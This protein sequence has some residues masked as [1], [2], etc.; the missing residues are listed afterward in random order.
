MTV[1]KLQLP[2]TGFTDGLNT[3]ASALNV[4]PSELMDGSVN[5]ELLRNGEIRRRR[6]VDFIGS[7]TGG[8]YLQ[9]IRTYSL[10]AEP[11]MESPSGVYVRL[12]A[13]NGSIVERIVIDVDNEFRIYDS[14]NSA[15]RNFDSPLQTIDRTTHSSTNQKFYPMAFA[16]SGNKLFFAGRHTVPGFMK[17]DDDNST[18]VV[19]YNDVLIRDPDATAKNTRRQRNSKWYECIEAHT[20]SAANRPGDGTGDWERYWVQLEGIIASGTTAWASGQAYTSTFI[21]LYDKNVTATNDETYPTTVEV[22]SG[23]LILS[24]DPKNSNDI[25][26][27]RVIRSDRDVEKFYQFADPFDANDPDLV[28]DDGFVLSLQGSGAVRQLLS[29]NAA[30]YVGTTTGVNQ[31]EG[32]SADFVA[33]DFSNF[34]VLND[35]I[36]NS[37]QMVRIDK[38]FMVF[39]QNGIWVSAI[40]RDFGIS[41]DGSTVFKSVSD[42]RVTS[43][44]SNIPEKSK[45]SAMAVY[46]NSKKKV[47]YFFNNVVTDFDRAY[48]AFDNPGYFTHTLVIDATSSDSSLGNI[49]DREKKIYR[50]TLGSIVLYEFADNGSDGSPYISYPFTSIGVPTANDPV[51]VGGDQVV[52]NGEDVVT[53]GQEQSGDVVLFITMG[54][55]TTEGT[56]TVQG[57]FG[58]L[59]GTAVRDWDQDAANAMS[60]TTRLVTGVSTLGNVEADKA[61]MYLFLVFKKVESDVLDDNGFDITPGGCFL[62]TA[63]SFST[64]AA[65][66]KYSAQRQVYVPDRFGYAYASGNYDGFNHSWYRHRVRGRG[67]VLSLVF[68]NDGDKDFH[69]V[70]WTYKFHAK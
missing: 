46:S 37:S 60:Y 44:Y 40:E 33:T 27:S 65:S 17:V 32:G 29:V 5:A 21:K 67:N 55:S 25:Y 54:L 36:S 69:L 49:R 35:G 47:Y 23:R 22:F 14:T 45:N 64:S 12:T 42:G 56:T 7:S 48:N 52:S 13:P 63:F 1:Q 58:R 19:A 41:R 34:T 70:G 59:D 6:G 18:L 43:L 31:I 26:V 38:E 30:L 28:E 66:A 16:K 11:A 51:V 15:L 8:E 53:S 2:V 68:D 10:G 24:G 61:G 9:D 62:R 4:L 3:E 20:S 57:A 50:E 39:G